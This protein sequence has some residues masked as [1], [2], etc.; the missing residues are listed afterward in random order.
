MMSSSETAGAESR[1]PFLPPVAR[2]AEPVVTE[3]KPKFVWMLQIVASLLAVALLNGLRMRVQA[4]FASHE[5]ILD[6]AHAFEFAIRLLVPLL[7]V[8]AP[9][10]AQRRG[11]AGWVLGLACLGLVNAMLIYAVVWCTCQMLAYPWQRTPLTYAQESVA[12]CTLV[13]MLALLCTVAFSTASRAWFRAVP[14]V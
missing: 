10:V 5:P 4:I 11:R 8:L 3:R 12:V 2:L 6:G 14:S 1:N 7:F 13:A 9:F